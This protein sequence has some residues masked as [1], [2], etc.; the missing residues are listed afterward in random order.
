MGGFLLKFQAVY[1][2][3]LVHHA[4]GHLPGFKAQGS[5]RPGELLVPGDKKM[6]AL[7]TVDFLSFHESVKKW[8]GKLSQQFHDEDADHDGGDH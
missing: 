6:P 2:G 3:S 1:A 8:H 4:I 7:K 5:A